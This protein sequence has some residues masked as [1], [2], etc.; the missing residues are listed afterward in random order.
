MCICP[1]RSKYS[2][3]IFYR[4][5][6]AVSF[7]IKYII[8]KYIYQPLGPQNTPFHFSLKLCSS[9]LIG[10]DEMS[11][12]LSRLQIACKKNDVSLLAASNKYCAVHISCWR[13]DLSE[14]DTRKDTNGRF[15]LKKD[16]LDRP[17]KNLDSNKCQFLKHPINY[18]VNLKTEFQNNAYFNAY[19]N[20]SIIH[21]KV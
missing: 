6:H 9:L 2:E 7:R 11:E 12:R 21:T 16:S 3:A 20:N 4:A 18:T 1:S 8:Q 17:I 14:I 19:P 15:Q 5:K 13:R 10:G